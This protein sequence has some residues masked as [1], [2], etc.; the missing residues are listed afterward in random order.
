M[1]KK[2]AYIIVIG[3]LLSL[4]G[5]GMLIFSEAKRS[6]KNHQIHEEQY[7]PYKLQNTI[8]GYREFIAKYP[9]NLFVNEAKLQIE[10]L[11][12]SPYEREDNIEGYMEFK[13]RYPDNRY[14]YKASIKIEQ[15]EFKR[16][17]KIDT[18]EA[19]KEFLLKYPESTFAILAKE[20]LQELEFRELDRTFRKKYGFDLLLYRLNLKRLKKK[21]GTVDGVNLGDFVCFVSIANHEGK[22][23]F[24]TH[25]IYSTDLSYL[26]STSKEVSEIFFDPLVSKTL[27]Y[28]NSHFMNKDEIDGFSFDISSSAHRFYGD[29]KIVCE[30]YFPISEVNLFAQNKLDK[31]DLLARSIIVSPRKVV[32]KDK[33]VASTKVEAIMDLKKLDGLKIMTLVSE[34]DRG[35]DY[36]IS[37]SWERGRHAL[38]SIEKRKNLMGEGAFIYKSVLRYIDPPAYYGANILTWNYKDSEKAFWAFAPNLTFQTTILN[39]TRV[40]NTDLFIPPAKFDFPLT[41][42]VDTNVGEERH[43]LIRS[44]DYEGKMCFVVE[45][46][47]TKKDMKYGKRISWI[48]QHSFIPLKVDYWDKRVRLWKTLHI[49]WQKKFGFWFWKKAEV[50]NVQTDD[51][52]FIIIE[53][54]RV[55]LGLNDRDFTKYALGRKKHGF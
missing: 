38:K 21:L 36:I 37:R 15:V 45:S 53:D 48:D 6:M 31:K 18:I 55:N 39:P 22:E 11:E 49:K 9:K 33:E 3:S 14:V 16:Y 41:D 13:I 27:I 19:Y 32:S 25:L 34:R 44:E 40:T 35:S 29:R 20:R 51:K 28:L 4:Q 1:F 52:T 43:N 30:Y 10:N 24:H 50:E 8:E 2:Y 7:N 46:T 26:D 47:P 5:C 17:E 23:Y 42:Y 12:F 54:V